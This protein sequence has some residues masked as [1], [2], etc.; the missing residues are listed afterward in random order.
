MIKHKRLTDEGIKRLKPKPGE[1]YGIQDA[2]FPRLDI[3]VNYAGSKSWMARYYVGGKPRSKKLGE[4]PQMGVKAARD[5]ARKFDENP[6]A[7]LAKT[8][9]GSFGEIA[10]EFLKRHVHGNGNGGLRSASDVERSLGYALKRWKDRP[11]LEIRRRDVVALLDQIEEER[12]AGVA[13]GVLATVRKLMRWFA[14]RSDDYTTPIVP[15]M[16]RTK[17]KA[18][19]RILTDD[20]IRN[21]WAACDGVPIF[22]DFVK[23]LLLTG[24]RRAK[25]ATMKWDDIDEDG[26]WTI[27]TEA[28]EKGNP[29][30]L[31]LPE[32]ALEIIRRQPKILN[33]PYVFPG[34]G[35]TF[36]SGYN[37]RMDT[38]RAELP[39]NNMPQWQLHDL[40]RTAR[41]LL[42][43]A[44]IT[45]HISERVLGHAIGGVEGVYDRHSYSD[46]KAHALSRLADLIDN[47][48]HAPEG[49]NIVVLAAQPR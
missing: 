6:Q 1:Q 34:R 5:A 41:S 36:I 16:R 44:G 24:Q 15:G 42:S 10:A 29:G 3:R 46:E 48:L 18:R 14:A 20:E 8:E 22:G 7:A 47:I 2:L 21:V 25:I 27:A 39:S 23:V 11:F 28:R 13:D 4:F 38:L 43:R 45:P 49:E 33:C 37:K 12:G 40:R 30:K 17:P 26:V 32:Q 19:E 9:V 35:G 31:P